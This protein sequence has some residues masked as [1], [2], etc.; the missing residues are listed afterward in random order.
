MRILTEGPTRMVGEGT[1][2]EAVGKGE[3]RALEWRSGS[4]SPSL[5]GCVILGRWSLCWCSLSSVLS[6]ELAVLIT[7]ISIR[8]DMPSSL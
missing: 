5:H 7:R 4:L 8:V 1:K 3:P 6:R 2:G